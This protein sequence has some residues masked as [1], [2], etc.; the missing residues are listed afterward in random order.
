MMYTK[1]YFITY[2]YRMEFSVSLVEE[3]FVYFKLHITKFRICVS[4]LLTCKSFI[5]AFLDSLLLFML[6]LCQAV[7]FYCTVGLVS[8]CYTNVRTQKH[9]TNYG[10]LL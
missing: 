2:A 6:L 7:Y 4:V 10:A 9:I 1:A 5:I 3:Y 8:A